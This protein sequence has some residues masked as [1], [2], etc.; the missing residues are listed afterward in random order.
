MAFPYLFAESFE[1]GTLGAFNSEVDTNS[2]MN[3]M[4]ARDM[5]R[6]T[7]ADGIAEVPWDGAYAAH[8]NLALGA[9]DAY[10][11][12]TAGFDTSASG[13]IWVRFYFYASD[14]LTMAASDRFTIFALFETGGAQEVT[15]GIRN[16]A[17]VLELAVSETG[18]S[19]AQTA[20]LPLGRWMHIELR[21]VIDS[22]AA[23]GT[24]DAYLDG[25]R[26]GSQITTLTQ[27]AITH[28]R[29]GSID[30]DAGTT[31]GRLFFDDIV[32]DDAQIFADT[33]RYPINKMIACDSHVVLGPGR[34]SVSLTGTSTDAV[35]TLYDT[36]KANSSEQ[37][38]PIRIIRNLTAN[39][40][41]GPFN[42]INFSRGLFAT[43]TGTAAHA[44]FE[45]E[46][47]GNFMS[48]AN[49]ADWAYKLK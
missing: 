19:T 16:N 10:I 30:I 33:E 31:L 20:T 45:I 43:L 2:K 36:N 39:E 23:N 27:G 32:A 22:G 9:A 35:L 24:I 11:E 18:S 21:A 17:G 42:D 7:S 34:V 14:N 37:P 12:E 3:Y 6:V 28:A 44:V 15:V 29:F 41:V 47:A 49:A 26:V 8:I 5:V 4:H 1:N 48:K 40:Y 25:T 46:R 38:I 13:T